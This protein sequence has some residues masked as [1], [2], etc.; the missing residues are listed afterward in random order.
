MCIILI[1]PLYSSKYHLPPCLFFFSPIFY[2][3][4]QR[5]TQRVQKAALT[6]QTGCLGMCSE[7]GVSTRRLLHVVSEDWV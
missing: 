5:L 2:Q 6:V 1:G 7:T 4:P 3:S